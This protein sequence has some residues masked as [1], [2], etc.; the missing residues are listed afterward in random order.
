MAE[1]RAGAAAILAAQ[2]DLIKILVRWLLLGFIA[3]DIQRRSYRSLR[4]ALCRYCHPFLKGVSR[5]RSVVLPVFLY[6][7]KIIAK[8]KNNPH[9]LPFHHF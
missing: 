6:R 4:I 1:A 3:V 8:C 7:S 9:Y 5:L 2:T